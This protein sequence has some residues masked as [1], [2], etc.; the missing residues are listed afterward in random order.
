MV[1]LCVSLITF[2]L[3]F[4]C[5]KDNNTVENDIPAQSYTDVAYGVDP[6]QKMDIYL[7]AD[8][9]ATTTKVIILVH[10]GGWTIGDKGDFTVYADTLKKRLP[11]YAIFNINYRLASGSSN[12]FP[13]QENDIKEGVE[14]IYNKRNEYGISDKFVLLGASAGAHLSLLHAYK[15]TTPVKIKAVV[16]FFGPVDLVDMYNNPASV[17]APPSALAAVIGATPASNSTLYQQSSPINFVTAQSSPTIILQGGVDPL[18]SPSQAVALQTKLQSLGVIHQYIFYPSETH[19]WVDA[20]LTH[21]FNAIQ[22]FL[23]ANVN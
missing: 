9:T 23:E 20:T 3:L 22:A 5:R 1:K 17:L 2:F 19:G 6:K 13:A 4:G 11:G 18:V 12:L 7:P 21:S 10:G 8:R 16:D 15:Y 14:F